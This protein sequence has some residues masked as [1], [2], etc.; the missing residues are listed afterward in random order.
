MDIIRDSQFIAPA[1]RCAVIAIGNFDGVHAGHAAVIDHARQ[2]AQQ[3]NAPL[4]VLTFEPHPRQFFIPDGPTFR[5]MDAATRAEQLRESGV[6]RLYELPFNSALAELSAED[7]I[8][9]ILHERLGVKH[10]VVGQD[11]HFGKGRSGNAA[12]LAEMGEHLGFGVTVAPLIALTGKEVSST[13][14][15]TALAEGRPRDAAAMLGH[16]HRIEGIVEHGDQRGRELGF[17]TAN[18]G[19]NGLHMPRFGVYA[20]TVIVRDGP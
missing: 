15:R 14:I 16:V 11:F 4:G 19:I 10:V 18:I 5:L 6:Q 1:Q 20:T 2:I 12:M 17:P 13:A 8:Q 7:F 3:M 9:K